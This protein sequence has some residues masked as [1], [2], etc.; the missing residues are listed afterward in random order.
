MTT[1][2]EADSVSPAPMLPVATGLPAPLHECPAELYDGWII[3]QAA[4]RAGLNTLLFPGQALM[5]FP[6]SDPTGGVAFAH[7]VSNSTWLSSA[8]LVQD[9][10]M[11]RDVVAAAGI[12]V[13]EGRSFSLKRG[14][15]YAKVFAESI[16]YPVVVKPMIGESTVEVMTGVGDEEVLTDAIGYL[17]QVPTIRTNFTTSSYAFTQVLTPKTSTSKKT[18][19]TY[20]YLVEKQIPGEYLRLLIVD[21]QVLS[22]IH[23]PHGPWLSNDEARDITEDIHNDVRAFAAK[24]WR[25]LPGLGVM[26]VD[27]VVDQHD[28]SQSQDSMVLVELS[29]RPWLHLQ[30]AVSPESPVRIGDELLKKEADNQDL[31]LPE[32]LAEN[33][34]ITCSFRWEGLSQV[35]K[36]IQVL[37]TV[38]AQ[39]G[40]DFTVTSDDPVAGVISGRITGAVNS[41][42]LLSELVLEGD[43]LPSPAMV[44]QLQ[45]V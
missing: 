24:V 13:P 35:H 17:R 30:G 32:P 28:E 9:K 39:V 18:R 7:G 21:G 23:A 31:K 4:L 34:N 41:V 1:T 12:Q 10:R 15:H 26:A 40:V 44:A 6:D 27:V 29:E 38:A 3:H 2:P 5:A 16:G 11:R 8:T 33:D 43:I 22:A 14:M 42:A 37:T 20:R 19:G 25:A 45:P 36:D